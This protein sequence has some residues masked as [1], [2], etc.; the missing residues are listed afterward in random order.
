MNYF[1]LDQEFSD[2]NKAKVVIIPVPYE[3]TTSYGKGTKN[4][5][6][7]VLTASQQVELF[8]EEKWC[9]PYKVGIATHEEISMEPVTNSTEK[10]FEKLQNAVAQV[11][12]NGQFP[13]VVGGEHSL[14][15]GPV[16][17][18]ANKY[19]D[20]SILHIDAHAD[21]RSSYEDNDY[22]HATASYQMYRLL[23]K[24]CITQVGIRNISEGEVAWLHQEK[25]NINIIWSHQ[26]ESCNWEE[27]VNTLSQNVYLT[28]DVDGLDP[29]IMPS[30]GTPEP[31]GMTF[32]QLTN[33]IDVLCLNKT[34]VAADIV[35]LAPIKDLH[36]PD[37]L[38]AKL[39]YKLIGSKFQTSLTKERILKGEYSK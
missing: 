8:D 6:S 28:I 21:L 3:A 11:L 30:T 10:P 33:L 9:T 17:A 35:E 36:A 22:S 27:V 13:I 18:C 26:L 20:L 5:P 1:G 16:K 12:E 29:S 4:G 37:F 7:A 14:S 32:R 31:D 23:A 15:T 39:I 34:V 2:I 38:A 19:S 24:P 25:P